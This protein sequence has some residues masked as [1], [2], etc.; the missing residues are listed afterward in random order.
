M[1]DALGVGDIDALSE[2]QEKLEDAANLIDLAMF[3]KA[4]RRGYDY[5]SKIHEQLG[6][7]AAELQDMIEEYEEAERERD[8]DDED[9]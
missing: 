1:S 7:W 4:T 2:A 9:E 3:W 8:E 6:D 5:W